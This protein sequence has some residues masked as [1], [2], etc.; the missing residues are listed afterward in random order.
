MKNWIGKGMFGLVAVALTTSCAGLAAPRI[1]AGGSRFVE[2]GAS[3]QAVTGVGIIFQDDIPAGKAATGFVGDAA[4]RYTPISGDVDGIPLDGSRLELD[5]GTRIYY[6]TGTRIYQPF[7]GFGGTLQRGRLEDP[8][9][10]ARL[11]KGGLYATIGADFVLGRT[12]LGVAY[13]R[14]FGI[15]VSIDGTEEDL[16]AEAVLLSIGWGL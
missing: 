12:R 7:V 4:I 10:S 14:T 6:D 1:E 9:S 15:D 13:R 2:E 11:E 8:T 16:D 3:D 5:L